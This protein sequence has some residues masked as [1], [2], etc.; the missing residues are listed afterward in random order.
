MIIYPCTGHNRQK[1]R[2]FCIMVLD[3]NGRLFGK[4][5]II[6]L[7]ALLLGAALLVFLFGKLFAQPK[8]EAVDISFYAKKT[9]NWLAQSLSANTLLY[10]GETDALLGHAKTIELTPLAESDE[11][12][13]FA[14]TVRGTV[15]G[16]L[17]DN[18]VT[19]EGK[20]YAIGQT[21]LL[22]IG[23]TRLP[24]EIRSIRSTSIP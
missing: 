14:V 17:G 8:A 2:A 1:E 6:D 23:R 4:I 18:G 19:L 21:V 12:S 7:G 9:E 5:N 3:Q 16:Q 10:D 13:H 15:R 11:D 20:L 22:H 24:M